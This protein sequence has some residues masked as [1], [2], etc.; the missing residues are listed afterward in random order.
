MDGVSAWELAAG[1]RLL[2]DEIPQVAHSGNPETL[3]GLHIPS[4]TPRLLC[5]N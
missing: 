4:G 3:P 1:R 2:L 5:Q